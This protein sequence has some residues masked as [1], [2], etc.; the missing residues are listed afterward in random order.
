MDMV[1]KSGRQ[2]FAE[3][4]SNTVNVPSAKNSPRKKRAARQGFVDNKYF[5]IVCCN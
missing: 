4:T 3:V 1:K 5:I 2:A